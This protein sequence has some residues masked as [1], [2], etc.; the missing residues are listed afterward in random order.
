M[1]TDPK[2]I[3]PSHLKGEVTIIIAP[4]TTTYNDE[5]KAE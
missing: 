1:L 5:L 2:V 3:R 4:Y